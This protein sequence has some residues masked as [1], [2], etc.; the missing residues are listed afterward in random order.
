M[1]TKN[2]NGEYNL[3]GTRKSFTNLVDLLNCYRTETV[4]SDKMIFQFTRCCPPKPKGKQFEFYLL[5]MILLCG[6]TELEK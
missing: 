4:R 6:L 3:T 1:I 5:R 2:E